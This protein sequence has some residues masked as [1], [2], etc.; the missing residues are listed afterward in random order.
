M[1]FKSQILGIFLAIQLDGFLNNMLNF[2]QANNHQLLV[3]NYN[4][5]IINELYIYSFLKHHKSGLKIK[6]QKVAIIT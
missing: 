5:L 4:Y 3:L 6:N 1:D 2:A